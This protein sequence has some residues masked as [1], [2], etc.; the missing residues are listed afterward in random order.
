MQMKVNVEFTLPL[1]QDGPTMGQQ[2]D[3][4]LK[5]IQ[6]G[7]YDDWGLDGEFKIISIF[8]AKESTN[9]RI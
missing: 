2:V 4:L 7:V 3:L 1:E 5:A 8:S 9:E 6:D